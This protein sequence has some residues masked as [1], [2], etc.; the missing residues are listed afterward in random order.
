MTNGIG[1]RVVTDPTT[2]KD[3]IELDNTMVDHG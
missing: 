3:V 2:K 1:G